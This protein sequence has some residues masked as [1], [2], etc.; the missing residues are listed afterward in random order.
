MQFHRKIILPFRE[1]SLLK[2][3]GTLGLGGNF[4]DIFLE[5]FPWNDKFFFQLEKIPHALGVFY[6]RGAG[7]SVSDSEK[8]P[9]KIP[10]KNSARFSLGKKFIF[11]EKFQS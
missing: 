1:I 4:P 10:K 5:N 11:P 3:I 9:K 7:E 8:F 2:F 6:E